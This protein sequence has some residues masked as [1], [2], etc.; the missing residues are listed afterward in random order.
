MLSDIEI[1]QVGASLATLIE[2]HI[3]GKS[4]KARLHSYKKPLFKKRSTGV[5]PLKQQIHLQ[6]FTRESI[7]GLVSG[8]LSFELARP[9]S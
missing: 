7:F 2:H 4:Q 9:L 6:L 5:V 8:S 1:S 3:D